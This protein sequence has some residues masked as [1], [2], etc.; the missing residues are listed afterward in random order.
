MPSATFSM[1]FP[2]RTINSA[3]EGNR[4]A[5]RLST[6]KNPKS[7]RHLMAWLRPAPEM[8]VT[9]TQRK[10]FFEFLFST[11]MPPPVGGERRLLLLRVGEFERGVLGQGLK[12]VSLH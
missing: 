7:S 10:R 6:Q 12:E 2:E 8:P 11:E 9:I 5:G 1:D 4:G 3:K